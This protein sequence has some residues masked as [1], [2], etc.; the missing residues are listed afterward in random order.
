MNVALYADYIA[1]LRILF[2]ELDRHPERFQ[3]F[4]IRLELVAAGGLIVYETKRRK[5]LTDSI[6]YG[7]SAETSSNH[8]ISQSTAYS[9]IDRF[10]A[11]GQ[12]VALAG[13]IDNRAGGGSASAR[14][15][16]AQYPHC[17]VNFSYRKK[18]QPVA[19]SMLMVF[20]GFNDEADA[21][22]RLSTID[23][24]SAL[25]AERP[26]RSLKSYEWK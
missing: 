20:I 14:E 6:Y 23:D 16:D 12:F 5:G 21:L 10:F 22:Q 1:D 9:A 18:G 4:N 15:V 19:R 8:Q 13:G 17:A 3:T 2:A 25:V 26:Y 24:P 7:H 11:L